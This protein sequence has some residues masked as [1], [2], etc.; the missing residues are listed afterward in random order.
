MRGPFSLSGE[1]ETSL[2]TKQLMGHVGSFF[3]MV[4]QLMSRSFQHSEHRR[5]EEEVR[6]L[7]K[8]IQNEAI[9][10]IALVLL[11]VLSWPSLKV[12]STEKHSIK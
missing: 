4:F 7:N 3:E 12:K 10:K 2:S 6:P 1:K 5:L 9:K 11:L 8:V